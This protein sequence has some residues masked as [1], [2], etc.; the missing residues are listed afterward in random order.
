MAVT[1]HVFEREDPHHQQSDVLLFMAQTD[2]GGPPLWSALTD[3][4]RGTAGVWS[5]Q[6]RMTSSPPSSSV[7]VQS[8]RVSGALRTPRADSSWF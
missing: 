2:S 7:P 5:P 1:V 3:P 8:D 6:T 4:G